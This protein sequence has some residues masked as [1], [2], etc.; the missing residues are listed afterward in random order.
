MYYSFEKFLGIFIENYLLQ[1]HEKRKTLLCVNFFNGY[2]FTCIILCKKMQMKFEDIFIF[3]NSFCSLQKC[4]HKNCFG[5]E[6]IFIL[7]SDVFAFS[8]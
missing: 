7:F 2:K 5:F 1:R 6:K 4:Y 3:K 8:K